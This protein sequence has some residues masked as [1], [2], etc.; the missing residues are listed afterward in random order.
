MYIDAQNLFSQDQ[1]VTTG[2]T[3]STNII[4]LG[5]ARDIGV[6]EALWLHILVTEAVTSGGAGTVA[7]SL[8]T[9]DNSSFS[10]AT[11][12]FTTTAIAKT[13]MVAGYQAVRVRIPIGT[14]RY[15]RVVYTVATADLTAGKFTAFL[16][17][18]VQANTAYASGYVAA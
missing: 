14:E 8:Q 18:N 13:T 12:L 4:D 1:A 3:A 15:L 10:S 11:T 17:I 5:A 7:F 16:T 2:A 9:D 6:G